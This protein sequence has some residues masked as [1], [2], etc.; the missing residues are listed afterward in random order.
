MATMTNLYSSQEAADALDLTRG[1]IRQ[2]CRWSDGKIGH[3]LGRDWFLTDAD[4]ELIR[5]K[6][7]KKGDR[8]EE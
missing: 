1:R 6:F 8:E 5:L 3:K 7:P 4:L 2:I